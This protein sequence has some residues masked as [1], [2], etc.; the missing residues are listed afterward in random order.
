MS[1]SGYGRERY[2][3][4]KS[5]SLPAMWR[6]VIASPLEGT[7]CRTGLP[8]KRQRPVVKWAKADSARL[9]CREFVARYLRKVS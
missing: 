8:L 6:A 1:D 3:F 9:R 7:D 2:H 5:P 4:D